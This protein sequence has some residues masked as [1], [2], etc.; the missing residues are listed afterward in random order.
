MLGRKFNRIF[1]NKIHQFYNGNELICEILFESSK[2]NF[3]FNQY[4]KT[5]SFGMRC[6]EFRKNMDKKVFSEIGEIDVSK[7]SIKFFQ[8]L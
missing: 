2:Y 3:S 1:S 5:K 7:G 6:K 8:R 4:I